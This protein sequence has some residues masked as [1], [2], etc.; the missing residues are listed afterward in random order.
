MWAPLFPDK[1]PSH[2]GKRKDMHY[3]KKKKKSISFRDTDDQAL[4]AGIPDIGEGPVRV[5]LV[6][7]NISLLAR[8]M[9]SSPEMDLQKQ[10][11]LS[12]GSTYPPYFLYSRQTS[13][14]STTVRSTRASCYGIMTPHAGEHT[15]HTLRRTVVCND[16][17]GSTPHHPTEHGK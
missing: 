4:L 6:S 3:D 11:I 12:D 1:I 10:R 14:S 15:C 13:D 5:Q 9:K 7:K 16:K 2:N 17:R 8:A